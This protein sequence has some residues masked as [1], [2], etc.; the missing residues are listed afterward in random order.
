[1]SHLKLRYTLQ[2][3]DETMHIYSYLSISG[4]PREEPG[5]RASPNVTGLLF[6][7]V[8]KTF[9]IFVYNK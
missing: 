4:V 1:M 5:S 9:E 6:F 2:N 3:R 8:F 7:L